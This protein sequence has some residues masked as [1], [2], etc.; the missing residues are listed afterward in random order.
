[1][2]ERSRSPSPPQQFQEMPLYGVSDVNYNARANANSYAYNML[3]TVECNLLNDFYPSISVPDDKQIS[4]ILKEANMNHNSVSVNNRSV[5]E[6]VVKVS[7]NILFKNF[8]LFN[9]TFKIHLV[10]IGRCRRRRR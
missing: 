5:E 9:I 6:G 4:Q 7:V 1:M 2:S 3:N 8:C 10:C